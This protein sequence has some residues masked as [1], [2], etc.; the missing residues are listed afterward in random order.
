MIHMYIVSI[1]G[2]LFGELR[3]AIRS[4][5]LYQFDREQKRSERPKRT[6]HLFMSGEIL[7]PR[8]I[9]GVYSYYCCM[10]VPAW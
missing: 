6:H 7:L 3:L 4:I 1:L 5:L 2:L 8:M 9:Y 10:M